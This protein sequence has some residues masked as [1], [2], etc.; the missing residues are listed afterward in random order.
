M[1]SDL[2]N[3]LLILPVY[4]RGCISTPPRTNRKHVTAVESRVWMEIWLLCMMWTE[5]RWLETLRYIDF[6]MTLINLSAFSIDGK[7][8]NIVSSVFSNL[9]N[10][11]LTLQTSSDGYFLHH[12]A[13]SNLTRISKN[14]VFIIDQ[15]GSMSGRKIEQVQWVCGR[16]AVSRIIGR[17]LRRN[18]AP[19]SV[20]KKKPSKDAAPELTNIYDTIYLNLSFNEQIMFH[21]FLRRE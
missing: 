18:A 5:T 14:V 4:R 17:F 13:P 2:W 20:F 9:S 3:L 1:H 7:K 6:V 21:L 10:F 16:W 11:L 12:F 19:P 15:S 8:K